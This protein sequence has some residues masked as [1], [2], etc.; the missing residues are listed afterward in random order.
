MRTV[1]APIL[2]VTLAKE[3]HPSSPVDQYIFS[4]F[5]SDPG[6]TAT[7]DELTENETY[8]FTPWEFH[9]K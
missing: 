4:I 6:E 1:F 7:V 2:L 3:A 8:G 5:S 9:S